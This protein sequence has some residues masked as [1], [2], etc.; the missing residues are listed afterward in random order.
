MLAIGTHKALLGRKTASTYPTAS[1]IALVVGLAG[2]VGWVAKLQCGDDVL[3][4]F[5]RQRCPWWVSVAASAQHVA[6]DLGTLGEARK[7]NLR[8]RAGCSVFLDLAR[9]VR[10]TIRLGALVGDQRGGIVDG[11]IVRAR[12]S[13]FDQVGE[14]LTFAFARVLLRATSS[15]YVH[16]SSTVGALSGLNWAS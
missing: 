14:G 12:D 3:A 4:E 11:N 13:G 6:N 7:N 9:H 16:A 1:A 2:Y 10:D 5:G 15:N 8:V